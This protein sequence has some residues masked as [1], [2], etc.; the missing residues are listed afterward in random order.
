MKNIFLLLLVILSSCSS[1]KKTIKGD[2]YFKLVNVIPTDGMNEE[3]ISK[4]E[5]TLES[6]KLQSKNDTVSTEILN[7][8][9]KLKKHNLL[10]IPSI[11]IET[12]DKKIKQVFLAQKE[13]DKIKPFTLNELQSKNKKVT[14]ELAL[15]ELDKDIYFSD[16]IIEIKEVNG[17]TPWGK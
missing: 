17:E 6:L 5:K 13:Y 7:Y 2:L 3:Q 9:A 4:I 10:K 1:D 15:Q 16:E 12:E 14:L 8:F 11:K